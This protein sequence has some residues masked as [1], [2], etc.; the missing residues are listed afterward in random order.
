MTQNQIG[1]YI[2][3]A[4]FPQNVEH[5]NGNVTSLGLTKREYFAAMAMQGYIASGLMDR[6]G[7]N[8]VA[9]H[10]VTAANALIETLNNTDNPN[11]QP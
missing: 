5:P 3:D 8:T 6:C 11:L 2:K 7:E 1:E 4:V 9:L 10:S